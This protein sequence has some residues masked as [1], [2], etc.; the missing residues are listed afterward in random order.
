MADLKQGS[1]G[2]GWVNG[3]KGML[4]MKNGTAVVTVPSRYC[5]KL[6]I[7]A[8][9]LIIMKKTVH[10]LGNDFISNNT[11]FAGDDLQKFEFA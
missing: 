2:G 11:P 5:H 9:P 8:L 4:K 3:E 7:Y 6:S 10:S 1:E